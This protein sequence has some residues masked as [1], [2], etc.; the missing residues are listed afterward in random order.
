[1]LKLPYGLSNFKEIRTEGYYYVDKTRYI[2]LLEALPEKYPIILRSRRF[3]KTLF[4]NMLGYYYDQR[5][6]DEFDEI[7]AGTY[8]HAHPTPK[9]GAYLMLTFNF[10]GINTE[11]LENANQGFAFHVQSSIRSFAT[12]Y[13]EYFSENEW[14]WIV[15]RRE[16]P[17]DMLGG[18]FDVIRTKGLGKCVY[19]VIDEYDHFANNI[20]SQGKEM[21]K[22]LVR[23]DGYVR[24]FYEALKA[25]TEQVVDRMFVTGVLPILLDSLTSGFNI[26]SNLSTDVRVN[27][28]FGFTDAEISPVLEALGAGVNRDDVR[29]YYNGYRFSPR[30]AQTVYNS[31]MIW[32]YGLKFAAAGRVDNMVDPN[33]I[34]DYRN[35]RAILSIGDRAVEEDILTR[36]V[37][38]RQVEIKEIA[39]LFILTH[40]TEFR[41]DDER[42]ISLLFYMGY[43]TIHA[44][45]GVGIALR[46]PNLVLE[47]LY[48]DYMA[49]LLTTRA[50]ITIRDREKLEM[51]QDL[52]DGKIERLT[53]LT[54]KLLHG[55]SNRDYERFDEKYIKV[56]MLSL[57]SDV[58]LY[59]PHS[60]YEVG[61]DG[62]VD[63]YLQAAFEPERSA[64]YFIELKYVKAKAAA[65]LI[66][67]KAEEGA[68]AMRR[69]LA[70]AAARA[71]KHLRGYVLV[72]RK[73]R[74]VRRIACHQ[75]E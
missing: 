13:R 21:F 40:E 53:A 24:P 5:H 36:I 47:S 64:S 17:N 72:F 25:G 11:T 16:R 55:L 54:E 14:E 46:M 18:L 26:G 71:A 22:E 19:V 67:R 65:A 33:V 56:V 10:S 41:F 35:I 37:H 42:L 58:N 61:A 8:I 23:T 73:D 6:A 27:E 49:H 31:D 75:V 63:I 66:D 70:S 59:V 7:F 28:M 30:A 62:Y 45:R 12:I 51:W 69:Y 39:Q 74:C 9:R 32:Y 68:A 57:L 20:L 44:R 60:E 34:S 43:L 2:E 52:V 38:E 3:G 50:A 4:A 29:V 48:F 15:E 1:M